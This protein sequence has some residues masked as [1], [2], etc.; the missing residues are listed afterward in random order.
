MLEIVPHWAFPLGFANDYRLLPQPNAGVEM[1]PLLLASLLASP[2]IAA[3]LRAQK[4]PTA[5]DSAAIRQAAVSREGGN[6]M[7]IANIVRD[8]VWVVG[9]TPRRTAPDTT[10]NGD[11]SIMIA[12][13]LTFDDW[14]A[15]VE[16][17]KGKWVLVRRSL[18]P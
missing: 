17:R 14:E 4:V 12:E 3:E 8:T 15:R 5:A 10:R 9:N 18:K 2:T 11:G 16:R 1:K 13:G 7:F 6:V